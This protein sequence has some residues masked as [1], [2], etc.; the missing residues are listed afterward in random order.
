MWKRLLLEEND[1]IMTILEAHVSQA[2][3]VALEQEYQQGIQHRDAGLE[4]S[5][6]IH[7]SKETDL[8]RIL[9]VW[10][11]QEALDEMRS[12]GET[13]RGVLMFRA[14]NAEPILSVFEIV[15]HLA[16]E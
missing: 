3:W 9:T 1:M 7:G 15:H 2:N 10:R 6:L 13:P 16:P 14:A 11:S 12:S 4:Q 8:W 5:F